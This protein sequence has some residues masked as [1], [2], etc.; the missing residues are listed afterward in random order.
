M[1]DTW[2]VSD[3]KRWTFIAFSF[4][5][6]LEELALIGSHS[7][8]CYINITIS[9]SNHPQIFLA[10]ALT[11]SCKLGNGSY[12]RRFRRLSTGIGVHFSIKNK[13]IDILPH[14]Q[15]VIKSSE[16][17]IVCP[18]ITAKNPDRFFHEI[19]FEFEQFFGSLAL[20]LFQQRN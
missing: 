16:T 7:H 11:C 17:D 3:N 8:L 4:F 18:T 1:T 2:R 13:H 19:T 15:Y 12:R 6:S 9:R 20:I 5:Q 10:N 14:C